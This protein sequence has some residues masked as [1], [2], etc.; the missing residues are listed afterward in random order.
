[1]KNKGKLNILLYIFI[2]LIIIS[3]NT[4]GSQIRINLFESDKAV[5]YNNEKVEINAIWEL[6]YNPI[7]EHAYIQ[8]QLF[9]IYDKNIWNS[10]TYDEIG[11]FEENWTITIQDLN[12]SFN[13]YSNIIFIKFL[14]CIYY[15][16]GPIL[17]YMDTITI[18][19]FKR[20]I[21]CELIG[22]TSILNYGQQFSFDAI[23]SDKINDSVLPDLHIL[24]LVKSNSMI[25]YQG[26][27]TTNQSGVILVNNS[28]IPLLTI[29]TYSFIFSIEDHYLYN[30]SMFYYEIV[31][32]KIPI[33]VD[34]NEFE[35]VLKNNEIIEMEVSYYYFDYLNA[36]YEPLKNSQIEIVV[37]NEGKVL[38]RNKFITNNSG[39]LEVKIPLETL[40]LPE[41]RRELLVNLLYNGTDFLSNN[42][43]TL[44]VEIT[45]SS[46]FGTMNSIQFTTIIFLTLLS[47]F[48]IAFTLMTFNRRRSKYKSLSEISFKY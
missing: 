36:S 5:Y 28:I 6:N 42:T 20:E 21:E 41:K 25:F 23:F 47:T 12:I 13:N 30:N 4:R 38:Y 26:N 39:I 11:V 22:F 15:P 8:I 35:N 16:I 40:G 37:F 34:I 10:S 43:L 18:E 24:F 19:I 29:G 46:I 44:N 31:V 27:F 7:T 14:H 33:L 32:Q 2:G 1:V 9:D 45:P 3:K 48:L 17:S